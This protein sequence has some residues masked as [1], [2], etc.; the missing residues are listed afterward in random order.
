MVYAKPYFELEDGELRLRQV[1]AP[2]EPLNEAQVPPELK[3]T[4]DRGG[5]YPALRQLVKK[6]NLKSLAQ[7]L[8]RYQP[9]PE[10]GDP[11]DPAWLLMQAILTAWIGRRPGKGASGAHSLLSQLLGFSG[12]VGVPFPWVLSSM[13]IPKPLGCS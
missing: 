11:R 3:H 7:R 5:R 8:T 10:Y 4:I 13:V 12:P 2:K 6:L 1:P 9:F